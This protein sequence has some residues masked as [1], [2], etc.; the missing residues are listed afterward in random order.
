[1]I[2]PNPNVVVA[3]VVEE[4]PTPHAII[5]TRRVTLL[6]TVRPLG[7]PRLVTRVDSPVSHIVRF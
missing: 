3:V 2:A 5:A 4:I 7:A 1:M 6:G